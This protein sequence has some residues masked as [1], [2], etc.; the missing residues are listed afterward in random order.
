MLRIQLQRALQFDDD[1]DEVAELIER[2]ESELRATLQADLRAAREDNTNLV[3]EVLGWIEKET[4]AQ[5]RA[6]TIARI[7]EQL[8]RFGAHKYGCNFMRSTFGGGVQPACDCGFTAAVDAI[9][10]DLPAPLVSEA[11]DQTVDRLVDVERAMH[12][13]GA[14]DTRD[15]VIARLKFA[16]RR[17]TQVQGADDAG[18]ST[19]QA[20]QIAQAA[21]RDTPAPSTPDAERAA[22]EPV[23][24][25]IQAPHCSSHGFVESGHRCNAFDD[26]PWDRQPKEIDVYLTRPPENG[27]FTSATDAAGDGS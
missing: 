13:A 14:P 26:M 11:P 10:N 18:G 23:K 4:A 9:A 12:A 21:L 17:I 7:G 3:N 27:G 1:N 19:W 2:F 6:A 5:E 22:A 25:W 16:L 20:A 8:Q 24:A 15:A